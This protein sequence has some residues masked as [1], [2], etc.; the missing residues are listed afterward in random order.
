MSDF[1]R[2]NS[3]ESLF[4]DKTYCLQEIVRMREA[5]GDR[6]KFT[7]E[8]IDSSRRVLGFMQL[9]APEDM[10]TTIDASIIELGK[11]EVLCLFNGM[12]GKQKE[13]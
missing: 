13:E 7:W 6:T 2:S 11:R 1:S 8:T 10:Q 5:W 4:S 3:I 9:Y 12:L